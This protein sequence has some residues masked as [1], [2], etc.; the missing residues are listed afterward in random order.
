MERLHYIYKITNTIN[1]KTYIGQTVSVKSRWQ[2]H[3]RGMEKPTQIIHHAFIKH[4]F[5]NFIFDIVAVCFDQDAANNA[6]TTIVLQENSLAPNGY[7]V[8]NGG[9]NSPKTDE[10]KAKVSGKNSYLYG[11][12]ILPQTFTALQAGKKNKLIELGKTSFSQ[13]YHHTEITKNIIK[14]KRA[15]QDM[16]WRKGQSFSEETKKLMSIK[17]MKLTFQ[18][19]EAIIQDCRSHKKIALQYSISSASVSRIKNGKQYKHHSVLVGP[20][21]SL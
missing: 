9:Y 6:E 10:W 19:I 15:K 12:K 1:N 8:T 11:K 5:D 14:E 4:G 17:K 3:K 20:T 16:S 7:N 21:P 2:D 18:E 13:G